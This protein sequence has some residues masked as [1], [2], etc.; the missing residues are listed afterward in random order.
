M[1]EGT[2][3][4]DKRRDVLV[5]RLAGEIDLSNAE[6]LGV[7][8]ANAAPPGAERVVLDLTEVEHI[9]SYGIFVIHGLRQRLREAETALVLVIPKD[10]RIRRALELVRIQESMQV[11]D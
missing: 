5:A 3:R 9:D 8:I 2:V 10:G 11:K 1:S 7:E 4:F 6:A